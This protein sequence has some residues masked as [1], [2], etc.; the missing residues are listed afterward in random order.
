MMKKINVYKFVYLGIVVSLLC[1]CMG[2]TQATIDASAS[3]FQTTLYVGGSGPGNYSTIGEALVA[4]VNGDIIYVYD[5]SSP[6]LENVL[7]TKQVEIFG[8]NPETTVVDGNGTGNVFTLATDLI[9]ISG[10]TIENGIAGIY[11]DI[12]SNITLSENIIQDNT[13]EGIRFYGEA[14]NNLITGN[15]IINNGD[16]G[17]HFSSFSDYNII[18]NNYIGQ[19]LNGTELNAY[20]NGEITGNTFEENTE[21]ALTMVLWCN[22][23]KIRFNNFMSNGN[24]V[25]FFTSV[26]NSWLFNYWDRPHLLPKPIFGVQGPIPWVNFDWRPLLSPHTPLTE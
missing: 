6:Y 20:A 19:N 24:D 22:Q 1:G 8:E 4:A 21:Y 9:T 26:L 17:I 10:F 15:T 5:D 18:S 2:C 23:N 11:I 14:N 13:A 7:V 16:C 3:P 25:M 12:H